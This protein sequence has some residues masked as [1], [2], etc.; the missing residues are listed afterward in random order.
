MTTAKLLLIIPIAT[1]AAFTYPQN[2]SWQQ[3]EYE[4]GKVAWDPVPLWTNSGDNPIALALMGSI[5]YRTTQAHL[6]S[7]L[8]SSGASDE[9]VAIGP[10]A[11][12]YEKVKAKW[13]TERR[14]SYL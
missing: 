9:F 10:A 4:T 2:K 6:V 3:C 12:H 5:S 8:L 14:R 1:L 13:H 7:G 11:R